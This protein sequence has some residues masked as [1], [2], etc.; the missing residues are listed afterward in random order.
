MIIN[1]DDYHTMSRP[2]KDVDEAP[3][4]RTRDYDRIAFG[5]NVH[6]PSMSRAVTSVK[7]APAVKNAVKPAAKPVEEGLSNSESSSDDS[8]DS[9]AQMADAILERFG[10]G[11]RQSR[12]HRRK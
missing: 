7:T 9:S 10:E 6:A 4:E 12:F 11:K 2:M 1:F 8:N 3:S 5:L